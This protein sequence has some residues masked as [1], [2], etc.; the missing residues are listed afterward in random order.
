MRAQLGLAQMCDVMAAELDGAARWLEQPQHGARHRRL[1]TAALADQP[2]G[3]AFAALEADPVD[4]VDLP[5]GATD[6]A[7]LDGKMFF[8]VGD[9]EHGGTHGAAPASR[10]ECQQAAQCLGRFCSS[11][12]YIARHLS[13]ANGQRGAK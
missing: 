3:F 10:S 9:L 2:Q 13:S 1:A 7:S 6:D 11:G 4:R 8:E 12:G 5:D